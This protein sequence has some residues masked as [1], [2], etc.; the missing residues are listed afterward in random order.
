MYLQI[1]YWLQTEKSEK[2]TEVFFKKA[3]EKKSQN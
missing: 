3:L 1:I 2:N